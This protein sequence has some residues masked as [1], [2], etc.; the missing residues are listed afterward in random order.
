M[1]YSY[2]T[3]IKLH[4]HNSQKNHYYKSKASRIFHVWEEIFLLIKWTARCCH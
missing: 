3:F 1:R 2:M 4:T